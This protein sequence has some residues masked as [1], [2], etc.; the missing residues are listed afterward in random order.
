MTSPEIS[1]EPPENY[2]GSSTSFAKPFTPSGDRDDPYARSKRPLQPRGTEGID[3]RFVFSGKPSR[4]PHGHSFPGLSTPRPSSSGNE[5][6]PTQSEKR[7]SLI[8]KKDRGH[9]EN[10]RTG[11]SRHGSMSDLKR[12]FGLGNRAKRSMSPSGTGLSLRSGYRTPPLPPTPP[13]QLPQSTA[14]FA[15]D[16]GL[17]TKY[18][19][20][21]KVLGS[22]AGGSVRLMK[23]S[24]DG[25]TFAVKEFRPRHAHENEKDYAKKV[26][27]EFC[28]G[29]ALHHGNI[30]ET[31]DIVQEKGRWYEVMEYAPYDLFA[32]VMT[33]K[34]SSKEIM[35]TFLQ[36]F[37]GVTYMHS[38]G[39]AHRDLKLDN[40]V[41][42]ERGIMKIIDFGSAS[43]F[44][45]PFETDI[46]LS[47]GT[48]TILPP[49]SSF[50]KSSF[51]LM[52]RRHRRIRPLS[53]AGGV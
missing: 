40:V 15:D 29:S 5:A 47:H 11:G 32:I 2:T 33:G 39:L 25:V 14:P 1:A 49:F 9:D 8:W 31:L 48:S 36:I 34:M 22:G 21:G 13:P 35:C 26:T 19:K 4:L 6:R 18:G 30:I 41:V 24:T 20:F 37:A 38:M 42:T 51:L 17:Q 52:D 7:H 46:V 28:I 43:V 12:F 3:A 10:A 53:R 45:Y 23:R 50:R 44:R 27:A 16:H